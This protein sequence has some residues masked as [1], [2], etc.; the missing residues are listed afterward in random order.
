[1]EILNTFSFKLVNDYRRK[2]ESKVDEI[3]RA[4]I[5][6]RR[7]ISSELH[8][9]LGTNLSAIALMSGVM[10]QDLHTERAERISIIAQQ[11]LDKINEIVW[12][13]NPKNDNLDNL[14]VFIRKYAM[15]YFE[16]TTIR[17]TVKL[18]NEIPNSLIKGEH[19]RNV[20]FA[21]K[22]ALY[23]IIKHAEATEVELI[24]SVKNNVLF[25]VIHDNGRGI[26]VGELNRFGNGLNNMQ[27][28]MKNINGNFNIENHEGTKITITVPV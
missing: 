25:V 10:K 3:Q 12:S 16:P 27:N 18:P 28:R 19:R 1:M 26:P 17:C 22:E 2:L 6:E 14:I 23:N 9:D 13:L 20:F 7:R 15:E 21:V 8:D 5:E 24:F 11:S 4:I